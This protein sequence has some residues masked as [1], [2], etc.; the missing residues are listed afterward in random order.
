MFILRNI[1][2]IKLTKSIMGKKVVISLI[3]IVILIILSL[4]VYFLLGNSDENSEL[5]S[6]LSKKDP[7]SGEG[8]VELMEAGNFEGLERAGV[9]EDEWVILLEAGVVDE[10]KFRDAWVKKVNELAE[11]ETYIERDVREAIQNQ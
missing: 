7:L 6:I 11:D 10:V 5:D 3:I 1:Y 8:P 4:A 2:I 9:T